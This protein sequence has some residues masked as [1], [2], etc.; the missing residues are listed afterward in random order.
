MIFL[1]TLLLSVLLTIALIPLFSRVAVRLKAFDLPNERKVHSMP[2]PRSGGPAM[3]IGVFVP[4]LAWNLGSGFPRAYAAG[5]AVLVLFG[6]FD[7]FRELAPRAKFAGQILAALIVIIFGG[8]SITTMGMLLP[9]GTVLAGW[10]AIP[11]TLLAIVGVTNAI[12]LADGLDGLAGGISLLIF[13]CIGFLAYLEGD[14]VI[15]L[16]ALSLAGAIF[17][18]LRFNT[19]PA[20]V[21]MGD[22]GSQLLGFSA[23]T[24]SLSL[25]QG[26]TAL[27]PLLPLLL[28]GFP[29]LDTLTVMCT[30]IIQG[31][32]PF[33][34]DKNHFHHN[35]MGIGLRHPESVLV[36]Y[37][38]QTI[39]VAA[40]LLLRFYSDWL[41]LAGYLMFSVV[42]LATFTA[43]GRRGWRIRR[44]HS[45]DGIITRLQRM[46][47]G[48]S[49]IKVTFR[50]FENGIPLLLFF[51]C[52]LPIRVPRYVSVAAAGF[53]AMIA[54]VWLL[55][56]EKLGKLLRI[57]LY[58][59]I[60]FAVYLSD[61]NMAAWMNEGAVSV[62]NGFF[63]LFAALII[64]VSKFSRRRGGFKSTP[65]DFL[66]L[67]IVVIGPNLPDQWNRDHQIGLVA[68]KIL[69]LYFCFEVLLAELRGK[70]NRVALGTTIALLALAVHGS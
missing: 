52:L 40:A 66:I 7:D 45:L 49:V 1:L 11:L 57:T 26:H 13:S 58:L 22:A 56:R 15:G 12:N 37:I 24:L 36:I 39:L 3:A 35:L 44:L 8:V 65:L 67:S 54:I 20:T 51:T 17:G 64:I 70:F 43:A 2:V 28:V 42:V 5:A 48:G 30:R 50:I 9:E 4:L 16:I 23:I 53:L 41:L 62:Y 38:I 29:V 33:S 59:L 14:T 10:I 47:D 55:D 61:H 6:L 46:R 25:T 60:P 19:H 69:I 31:R 68:A 27:S 63:G 21:F 34:A 18:F 32:S